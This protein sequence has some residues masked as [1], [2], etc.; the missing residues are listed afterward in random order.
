[1]NCTVNGIIGALAYLELRLDRQNQEILISSL[2]P[3]ASEEFCQYWQTVMKKHFARFI[4]GGL[5]ATLTIAGKSDR[6]TLKTDQ[7]CS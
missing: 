2:L 1:M 5:R 7:N 3:Y 6:I 4:C